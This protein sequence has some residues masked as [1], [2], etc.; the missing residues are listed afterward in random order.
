MFSN[1]NTKHT[2]QRLCTCFFISKSNRR[3]EKISNR[4]NEDFERRPGAKSRK[5]GKRR[6]SS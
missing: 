4:D 5:K 2:L 1:K 6:E 3:E